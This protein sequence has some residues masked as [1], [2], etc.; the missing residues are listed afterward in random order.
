MVSHS[1]R[2]EKNETQNNNSWY[3]KTSGKSEP[4]W[5]ANAQTIKFGKLDKDISKD[6]VIV[7]GGIAGISTAYLLSKT[8]KEVAVVEDG[9]VGSGETGRTTAHITNAL[10]DRYYNIERLYR[11]NGAYIAAHSHTAAI[12]LVDSIVKEEKID[13]DFERLDG[14]LFLDPSDDKNSLEKELEATHSA[15]ITNTE[16]IDKAPLNSFNTGPCLRFPNQAQFQ[17]L[18]YLA[19]LGHIIV[20]NGGEIFTQTHAQDIGSNGITTSEGHKIHAKIA[21]VIATNA[22]IRDETSKIYDK[23]RAYRTYVIG[24]RMKKD[25]IPKSLYWDTG[26]KTSKNMAPPYHYVRVQNMENREDSRYDLLIVGGEDHQTG[27]NHDTSEKEKEERFT[28][29]AIWTKERFPIEEIEYRWSGQVMETINSLAFI[30]HN[31]GDANNIYI[32]TGDSGN[33]MTHG[34]IAGM[35]L[36][37]LILGKDNQ[38]CPLYDPSRKVNE[39]ESQGSSSPSQGK[40][41]DDRKEQDKDNNLASTIEALAL[42]DGIIKQQQEKNKKPIAIYKDNNGTVQTF[43]AVCTHLG[44]TVTWNSLEK[45]FDCPCHGSRFSNKGTVI[46]GPANSNLECEAS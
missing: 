19:G 35:L 33:G 28:K 43:S 22:P 10:D 5:F 21:V 20:R 2:N 1:N 12:N 42:D 24:A 39:D 15:G 14:F 9:Y 13:C 16:L 4:S 26:D 8:G 31:P 3:D 30:G 11:K 46:N 7:G 36:T 29:L 45:S 37:D 44:C 18:K 25:S 17:P 34:T 41:D 27:T 32:A 40:N 38:W 6:V 23:Q